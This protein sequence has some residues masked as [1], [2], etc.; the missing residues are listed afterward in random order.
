MRCRLSSCCSSVWRRLEYQFSARATSVL[1]R[2]RRP[3]FCACSTTCFLQSDDA[4]A[5]M[6]AWEVMALASYFLVTTQHRIAEIRRAG[7]LYLL[8]A[9]VGALAI[10]LC[11]GILQG[12]SWALTFDTMRAAHLTPQWA[13]LAFLLALFGFGAK[14]GLVP[15]VPEVQSLREIYDEHGG[16]RDRFLDAGRVSPELAARLGLVGFAAR[17]SGQTLDPRVDFPCVPYVELATMKVVRMEG[18]VAARVAVRFDELKES[19]RLALQI[20][21]SLP[22]TP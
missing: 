20:L 15:L 11:F 12:G 6:F 10:L 18:D 2:A 22:S 19:C 9:H 13:T 1:G 16:V 8:I 21:K 4:Y 3:A 17:A 7:F 14:A 5:F